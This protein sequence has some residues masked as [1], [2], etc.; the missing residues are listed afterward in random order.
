MPPDEKNYDFTGYNFRHREA[1]K[2][3]RRE[4]IAQERK[5][6]FNFLKDYPVR[7]YP[8]RSIIALWRKLLLNSRS[9]PH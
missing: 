2:K 7:V 5:L 1:A 3:L 8:Q 9:L 6:W 4:M